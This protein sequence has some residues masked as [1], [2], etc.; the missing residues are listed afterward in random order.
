MRQVQAI[1]VRGIART[2]H[3]TIQVMI[4][5]EMEVQLLVANVDAHEKF[6]A[7]LQEQVLVEHSVPSMSKAHQGK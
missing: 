7:D 3:A 6:A 1:R 2:E 4:V 5:L